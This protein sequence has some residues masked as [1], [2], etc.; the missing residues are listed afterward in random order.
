MERKG[1][2]G[3]IKLTQEQRLRILAKRFKA[4]I[5][6]NMRIPLTESILEE[7]TDQEYLEFRRILESLGCRFTRDVMGQG[8]ERV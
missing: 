1:E 7:I 4:S 5:P 6:L 8:W 2:Q 3:M